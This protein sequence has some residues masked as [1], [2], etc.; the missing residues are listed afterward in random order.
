MRRLMLGLMIAALATSAMADPSP[1]DVA[2]QFQIGVATPED[3]IAKLGPPMTVLK[4][5]D[6]TEMLTY[7]R[8]A[9]H[10]KAA[11]FIPL[12][13]LFA[14]GAVS[15]SS[16]LV[17]MFDTKGLLKSTSSSSSNLDCSALLVGANCHTN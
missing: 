3:V 7:V 15:H 13:G 17:F 2:A 14:G 10:V 16:S 1:I 8:S 6:G 9:S 11:S 5:S 12:V 4:N